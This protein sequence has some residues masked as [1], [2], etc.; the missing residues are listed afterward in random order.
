[1]ERRKLRTLL[2]LG[3][4]CSFICVTILSM[5][6]M[7]KDNNFYNTIFQY[8]NISKHFYSKLIA[9]NVKKEILINGMNIS[10]ILFLM[11]NYG[12][13]QIGLNLTSKAHKIIR[14][15]LFI[16]WGI[17][18]VVYSTFFYKFIYLGGLGILPEPVVF[19]GFYSTF[20]KVTVIGN[21]FTLMLSFFYMVMN[22]LKKEPIKELRLMKW[23]L[24]IINMGIGILYFYMYFS[25][26]DSFLW[27]SRV[28]GYTAYRS[29]TMASYISFMRIIPYLVISFILILWVNSYRYEKTQK[30]LRDKEYV[31]STIA[32]SSEVS[33]RAFSHYI[34]NELLGIAAEA[35]YILQAPEER[36]ERLYTI[37]NNC[38]EAYERLDILQK[39]S[40]RIVLNQSR[41]DIIPVLEEVIQKNEDLFVTNNIRLQKHMENGKVNVFCDVHYLQSVFQNILLNAVEAISESSGIDREIIVET[42]LYDRQIMIEFK[43]SGHGI[44]PAILDNLFE[45]FISTK[46]TKYNWGIGLSF[47]KRIIQSH[48]GKIEAENG[49]DRGAVFRIYL[50]IV[51]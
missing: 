21:F 19:R 27:V 51:D 40:N 5:I 4:L 11:C 3:M 38:M 28:V 41:N 20:H 46:S 34:K 48:N 36:K 35:E 45:P 18:F 6:Y 12:L 17:Q 49:L 9:I 47:V 43:D 42:M 37:Q 10:S 39:N 25:L 1:M 15:G 24:T 26:P 31:F 23:A 2:V 44:S 14:I 13:S 32:A 8:F 29:I 50:P 22:A 33:T 16:F 30:Q 7:A